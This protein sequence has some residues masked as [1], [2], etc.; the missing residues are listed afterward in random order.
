MSAE[1]AKEMK[2]IFV[3]DVDGCV[4][5]AKALFQ[6]P[7]AEEMARLGFAELRD[8]RVHAQEARNHFAYLLNRGSPLE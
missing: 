2:P 5:D 4:E 1:L 6:Q 7:T 3:R 8:S